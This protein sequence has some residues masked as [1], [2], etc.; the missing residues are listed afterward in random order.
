MKEDFGQDQ[1]YKDAQRILEGVNRLNRQHGMQKA[2]TKEALT[3]AKAELR[4]LYDDVEGMGIN[5]TSQVGKV[6]ILGILAQRAAR[7]KKKDDD[8]DVPYKS[9]FGSNW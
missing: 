7:S 1:T 5:P 9:S 2:L 8:D 6:V 4:I 3:E